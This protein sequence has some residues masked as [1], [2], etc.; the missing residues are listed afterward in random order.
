MR[1]EETLDAEWF[2]DNLSLLI[3]KAA[4][5]EHSE[6]IRQLRRI[7]PTYNCRPFRR[8][9]TAPT[10]DALAELDSMRG[11]DAKVVA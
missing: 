4:M 9:H 6:V 8:Y 7:V 10:M 5:G 3:E 11:A 1:R 2:A